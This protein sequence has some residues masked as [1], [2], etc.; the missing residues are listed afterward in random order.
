GVTSNPNFKDT[1][2]VPADL[3][4]NPDFEVPPRWKRFFMY[5]FTGVGYD[6]VVASADGE[7]KPAEDVPQKFL[8]FNLKQTFYVGNESYTVWFPP[9][10]LL[11]RA[12]LLD[13]SGLPVSRTFRKGDTLVKMKS[14]SGDHLFVDRVTYNFRR[15]QRGE[16]IVFET[17]DIPGMNPSQ[18]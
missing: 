16:I 1:Y 13:R 15:P 8:L 4:P 17:K 3:A 2:A 12:G 7:L 18:Q 5:W 14:Y 11:R 10:N 6:Y 9:D